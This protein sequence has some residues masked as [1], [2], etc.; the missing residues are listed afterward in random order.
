M[1]EEKHK[2][3]VTEKQQGLLK[4]GDKCPDVS[5]RLVGC[6][7]HDKRN[8]NDIVEGNLA[9]VI[10][11]FPKAGSTVCTKE[12]CEFNHAF[13]ELN[14]EDVM[15]IGISQDSPEKLRSFREAH[16][17]SYMFAS[18]SKPAGA[19]A[20]AFGVRP[21]GWFSLRQQERATFVIGKD[22]TIKLAFSEQRNHV[23][24]VSMAAQ[25]VRNIINS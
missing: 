16:N 10:F 13:K 8:L 23:E 22:K 11:F 25:C 1:T 20:T 2:E 4:E 5:F 9:T 12:A 3:N 17:I 14:R 15:I 6:N 24:H 7:Q 19:I 21:S 18:D